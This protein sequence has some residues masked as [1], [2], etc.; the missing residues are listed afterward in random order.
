MKCLDII[1][2]P[3]AVM[4]LKAELAKKQPTRGSDMKVKCSFCGKVLWNGNGSVDESCCEDRAKDF[5]K[6][7]QNRF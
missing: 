7:G 3:N 4:N 5:K 2:A 6:E 1:N